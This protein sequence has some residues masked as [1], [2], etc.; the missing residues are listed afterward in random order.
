MGTD[1]PAS[2]AAAYFDAWQSNDIEQARPLFHRDREFTGA[3]GST[4][5]LD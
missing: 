3:L 5:G 4:W 1:S 2:V